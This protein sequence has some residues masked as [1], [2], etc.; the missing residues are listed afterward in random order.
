LSINRTENEEIGVVRKL[1]HAVAAAALALTLV[2]AQAQMFSD[3]FTF[4]KAVKDRDG[5]KVTGLI[6]TPGGVIIN[7]RDSVSGDG[8][9]HILTRDRDRVWLSFLLSKGARPD[10]QNKQGATPLAIAAQIGWVDGA[11][12]LLRGGAKVDFPNSRGETPLILAVHSRDMLMV[13]LLLSRGADPKRA[14][15]IA[16]YSALDYARQDGRSS[17]IAKMLEEAKPVAST[18]QGP[19]L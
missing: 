14:D 16:G 6:S 19:G 10:L 5:E 7:Y 2:P 1:L 15:S 9:L 3:G 8:A 13:R 11:D 12:I 4:L 17:A 18:V